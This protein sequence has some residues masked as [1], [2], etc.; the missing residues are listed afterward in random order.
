MFEAWR[1]QKSTLYPLI[2]ADTQLHIFLIHTGTELP[3]QETISASI[4]N[5]IARLSNIFATK[6]NE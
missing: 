6:D 3:T 2:P 4:G 5:L 1:L